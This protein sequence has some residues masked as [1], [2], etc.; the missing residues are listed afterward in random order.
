M[1]NPASGF[2]LLA[3]VYDMLQR[4]FFGNS[5]IRAQNHFLKS[6]RESD[7]VLI[8]GGGTGNILIEMLRTGTGENYHYIDI[9]K[10]MIRSAKRKVRRYY[11]KNPGTQHRPRI[12]YLCA[13]IT[14]VPLKTYD[15]IVTPFVLDCFTDKTLAT[16]VPDLAAALKPGGSWLFTDFHIPHGFAR[17]PARILI[18]FL[19]FC[20]NSVCVARKEDTARFFQLL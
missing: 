20:F 3:P 11:K 8:I 14:R 18:R 5:L 1:R 10:R 17:Y 4:L 16:L 13:N 7:S 15:L 19:Y 9:S 12:V 2:D 6:I